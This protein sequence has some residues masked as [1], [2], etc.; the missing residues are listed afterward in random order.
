MP[1]RTFYTLESYAPPQIATITAVSSGLL[2]VVW[3]RDKMPSFLP[4]DFI[5][6]DK[7]VKKISLKNEI[8]V[9]VDRFKNNFKK[10]KHIK[11]EKVIEPLPVA[12]HADFRF[13]QSMIHQTTSHVEEKYK[14]LVIALLSLFVL[15]IA[16]NLYTVF[17][18]SFASKTASV[19]VTETQTITP[20]LQQLKTPKNGLRIVRDF[21]GNSALADVGFQL[22]IQ[23][24]LIKTK[25]SQNCKTPILPPMENGCHF[26]LI[27]SSL[28]IPNKGMLYRSFSLEGDLAEGDKIQVE[29][30][31]YDK[32]KVQ[33]I[34]TITSVN[35]NQDFDLPE[36]I[37]SSSGILFRLWAKNQD[38]TVRQINLKYFSV[39]DLRQVSGNLM[40][41]LASIEETPKV[42][43]D[44]DQN[45]KFD[46][47]TDKAWTCRTSFP[48]ARFVL[49]EGDKFSIEPDDS[50]FNDVKPDCWYKAKTNKCVLPTGKWLLVYNAKKIAIQFEVKGDNESL[51]L[52][53][54]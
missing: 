6:E 30:K 45:G 39:D 43:L 24:N 12:T 27:P 17:Y 22:E 44:S 48:G 29:I 46:K 5:K 42:Y 26:L 36:N 7:K 38:I 2:S 14:K 21:A 1:T 50:C 31:D 34:S 47:D 9:F 11:L 19:S 3:L 53:L 4:R 20:N 23:K 37:P 25:G 18:L 15:L 40:G 35:I 51:Q 16:L 52:G 28:G 41:D 32:D 33:T 49:G 10:S 13:V 8:L 54:K